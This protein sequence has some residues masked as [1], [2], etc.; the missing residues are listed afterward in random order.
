MKSHRKVGE[1]S[2]TIISADAEVSGKGSEGAAL[3]GSSHRRKADW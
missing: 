3:A 1:L 2:I